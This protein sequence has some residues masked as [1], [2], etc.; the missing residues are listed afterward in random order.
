MKD[1]SIQL[2]RDLLVLHDIELNQMMLM[3]QE[4]IYDFYS[5]MSGQ[6]E[7]TVL[8]K[9]EQIFQLLNFMEME[10]ARFDNEEID[11]TYLTFKNS[12][13]NIQKLHSVVG[14]NYRLG[15]HGEIRATIHDVEERIN[16]LFDTVSVKATNKIERFYFYSQVLS[17]VIFL[18]IISVLITAV[19]MTSRL[20]KRIL[21]S[22][23][24]EI[25]ANKAKKI[26]RAHV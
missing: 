10:I 12:F 1:E 18:L 5:E 14:Y 17:V 7:V 8:L 25:K 3:L 22:Q 23:N 15:L 19:V 21:R 26:G 16:V 24:Q 2:E 9:L 20:E 6:E 13:I 4:K 11:K